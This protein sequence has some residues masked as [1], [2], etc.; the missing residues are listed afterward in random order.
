[1][2]LRKTLKSQVA[3]TAEEF[4][5]AIA[6][7]ELHGEGARECE[8]DTIAYQYDY[9]VNALRETDS[10]LPVVGSKSRGRRRKYRPIHAA[11]HFV[12]PQLAE[13]AD[14]MYDKAVKLK[15]TPEVIWDDA[16]CAAMYCEKCDT[17]GHTMYDYLEDPTGKEVEGLLFEKECGV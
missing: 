8:C 14:E 12:K 10:D 3:R 7:C 2:N 11:P 15:H 17:W 16:C 1:M 13:V 6:E 4:A 9:L 5:R